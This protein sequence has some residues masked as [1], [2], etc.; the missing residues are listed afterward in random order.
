M[1]GSVVRQNGMDG[2]DSNRTPIEEEIH[3]IR[4]W[5]H[6]IERQLASVE[7]RLRRLEAQ[8]ELRAAGGQRGDPHDTS[9]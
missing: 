1:R 3:K 9:K 5:K 7:S 4:L 8:R 2:H 6:E